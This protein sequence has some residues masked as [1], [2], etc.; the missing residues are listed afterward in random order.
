MGSF[1]E[2]IMKKFGHIFEFVGYDHQHTGRK[3]IPPLFTL[4]GIIVIFE[5]KNRIP[6]L[7]IFGLLGWVGMAGSW[8]KVWASGFSD[9]VAQVK[10]SIVAVGTTDPMPGTPPTFL[11]TG[12]VVGDGNYVVTAA[13]VTSLPLD[14][15]T[16]QTLAVYSGSARHLRTTVAEISASD[17][18]H[19][20]VLLHAAG[21]NLKPLHMGDS[22]R[23]REGDALAFTGFPLGYV[24]GFYPVTHRATLSALTPIVMPMAHSTD[25]TGRAI[26]QMPTPY[27]V[28]QLDATAYPGNSGSPLY[29]AQTGQVI[30]LLNLVMVKSTK[31]S[32]ISD[33]SGIAYAI[34]GEY[35]VQLLRSAGINP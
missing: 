34:P 25:L 17:P 13:H 2:K 7:L 32:L 12:F 21:L 35:I 30:G 33:P 29:E 24:L 11:G 23:L 18:V 6:Y 4:K 8:D 1:E 26:R 16:K 19:D 31:E 27:L 3:I 22:T 14:Y 28:F 5:Q 15:E 20:L 9:I 10:P